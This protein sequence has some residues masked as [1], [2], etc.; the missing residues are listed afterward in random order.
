MVTKSL[1]AAGISKDKIL[2]TSYGLAKAQQLDLKEQQENKTPLEFIFVGRVGLRKGIHLLLEY[3]CASDINATLKIIGNV[4]ES[5]KELIEPYRDVG[6]IQ[7]IS[8]TNNIEAVYKAADVFVLP[9]LEEGS[10]LVSYLSLGGGLTSIVSPM[11]GLGVVSHEKDGFV[12]DA[13]DKAGWVGALQL[14]ANSAQLRNEQAI[15]A[16]EASNKFLWVNVGAQR[17]AL[18]MQKLQER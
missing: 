18:L 6:N 14:L 10:P 1:L 3:W 12:I 8:F 7:F 5:I 13:H 9:S 15:A 17:A 2:E 16:R 11:G 4:E